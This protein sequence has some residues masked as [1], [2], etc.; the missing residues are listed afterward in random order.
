[1]DYD[2]LSVESEREQGDPGIKPLKAGGSRSVSSAVRICACSSLHQV[3]DPAFS[4][5]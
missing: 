4:S 2:F 3:R 5:F 1:M